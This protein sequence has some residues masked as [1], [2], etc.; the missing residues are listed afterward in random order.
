[1]HPSGRRES[2]EVTH[3]RG[4]R[5]AVVAQREHLLALGVDAEPD[6]PLPFGVADTAFTAKEVRAIDGLAGDINWDRLLFSAKEAI[7]K[8]QTTLG[9]QVL[10]EIT[11]VSA[12]GGIETTSHGTEVQIEARWVAAQ[13]LIVTSATARRLN[14]SRN[15]SS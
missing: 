2:S 15:F 7:F 11:F 9:S 6:A 12:D 4:Y 14:T 10:I 8:M 1:M 5:A 3:C 13:G